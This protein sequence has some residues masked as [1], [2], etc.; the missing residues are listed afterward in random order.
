MTVTE[1]RTG[2]GPTTCCNKAVS[3]ATR[4]V[5]VINAH[6][7]GQLNT[8]RQHGEW[9]SVSQCWVGLRVYLIYAP[10][11][12]GAAALHDGKRKIGTLYIII[13]TGERTKEAGDGSVD[14]IK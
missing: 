13:G 14:G 10:V 1:L 5:E 7:S 8:G 4:V 12:L 6:P 9:T 2:G 11:T 3:D